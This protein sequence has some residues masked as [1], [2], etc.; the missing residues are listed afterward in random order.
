MQAAARVADAAR[1]QD[2][3]GCGIGSDSTLAWDLPFIAGAAVK[4]KKNIH[5]YI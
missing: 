2:C 5:I 4:R 1:I 3:H